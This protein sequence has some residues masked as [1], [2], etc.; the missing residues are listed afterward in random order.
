MRTD[1]HQ[2]LLA[3]PLVAALSRRTVAPFV[4]S[5]RGVLTLQLAGEAPSRVVLDEPDV[6]ADLISADGLDRGLVALSAALG[7]EALPPDEADVLLDAYS[8]T[9]RALPGV[10]GAWGAIPLTE[11][12]PRRVSALLDEGFVGLCLPAGALATP[13][14]LDTI[15]PVLEVLEHR[16]APLFIHPGPVPTPAAGAPDW[17]PAVTDYVAGLQ[18]A[19]CTWLA[20]GRYEHPSLRVVFAALAGLAPLHHERLAARGAPPAG[21]DSYLFYDTSSYGPTAIASMAAAVGAGQLVYGSDRPVVEP[22]LPS[23]DALLVTNP[24]RLFGG[25]G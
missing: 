5:T 19:W 22:T 12:D 16:G 1:V 25:Q 18:A 4:E 20:R 6:R 9:A 2:H 17:W 14:A 11:P 3:E 8:S 21:R 23:D 24:A 7:I 10:F 15:G 13:A